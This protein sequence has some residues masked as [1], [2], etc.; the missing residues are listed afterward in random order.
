MSL[1]MS[2][3]VN[4]KIVQLTSPVT[5][6]GGVTTDCVSMRDALKAWAVF[7]MTQAVGHATTIALRQAT[8]FAIGT[9]AA[10]PAVPVWTNNDTVATD[11]LVKQTPAASQAVAADVKHKQVVFEIDPAL[12]TAGYPCIY[13]TV[14]DSSQATN[15][16]SATVYLWDRYQQATPPTAIV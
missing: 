3:P 2:L 6:N 4:C 11:T 1:P 9:N 16:V 13:F 8:D 7:D 10:G 15:F 14:S 12:L 5:S